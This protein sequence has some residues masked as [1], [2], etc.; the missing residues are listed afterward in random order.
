[1]CIK[2]NKKLNSTKS[3]IMY[4]YLICYKLKLGLHKNNKLNVLNTHIITT[5]CFK[6]SF[7]C[8]FILIFTIY[9]YTQNCII[10]NY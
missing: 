6:I 8:I 3:F 7:K 4:H 10:R 5:I 2:I 1:M 9:M